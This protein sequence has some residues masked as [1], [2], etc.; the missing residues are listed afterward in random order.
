MD[1]E[2]GRDRLAAALAARG[3]RVSLDGRSVLVAMTDGEPYDSVRD[4]LVE[5][6]LPLIRLEQRRRTLEDLFRDAPHEAVAGA[7]D[8]AWTGGRR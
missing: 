1:D 2:D 7:A 6:D 8:P 4:A 5:L 3:L